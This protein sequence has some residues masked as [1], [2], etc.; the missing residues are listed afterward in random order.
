MAQRL[1]AAWGEI[2]VRDQLELVR[3]PTL[4]AHARDEV[5]VPFEEGRLL[6]TRIPNARLLPLDSRN[7]L[8]LAD[9]PAWPVLVREVRSFLGVAAAP[10]VAATD[11]LSVRERDV[12]RLVAAGLSNEQ[13][14][15]RLCLSTRTVERHLS[16]SY[17]KLG[18][19]GKAARAAAAAHVARA[20]HLSAGG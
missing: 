3:A 20:D 5:I 17:A 16:N 6:A 4:I 15:E 19:T 8:L 12:L 2:D 18:V 13:V 9:E 14:A 1:R 10:P 11:L 7:H